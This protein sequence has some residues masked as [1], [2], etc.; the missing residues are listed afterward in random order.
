MTEKDIIIV[1]GIDDLEYEEE[2]A[3]REVTIKRN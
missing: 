3:I 1:D 2:K